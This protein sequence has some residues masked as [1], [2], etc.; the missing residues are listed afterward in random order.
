[1]TVGLHGLISNLL[2]GRIA[3]EQFDAEL[4]DLGDRITQIAEPGLSERYGTAELALAEFT[5]GHLDRD[6]LYAELAS[7]AP[8]SV[9]MYSADPFVIRVMT[10][11]VAK[12][13]IHRVQAPALDP[14]PGA[15][16]VSW[17]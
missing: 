3:I 13:V 17:R 2:G 7:L 16:P 15:G 8:I 5:S 6:G 12:P 1:S 14:S 4:A 9:Y 10:E 11:A